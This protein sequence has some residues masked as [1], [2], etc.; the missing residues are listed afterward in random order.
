MKPSWGFVE[1][2][3]A[4]VPADDFWLGPAERAH[5]ARL[6]AAPR[7]ADWRLGRW[8]AKRALAHW[9][10]GLEA[11][12]AWHRLEVLPD[13]DGRPVATWRSRSL[14]EPLSLSHRGGRA[15]AVVGAAG[16]AV[17]CDLERIEPRSE[18]FVCD[19]FTGPERQAVGEADPGLR[20]LVANLIWSAK[21]SVSKLLGVGLS[22]DTRSIEIALDPAPRADGRWLPFRALR[23]ARGER[24]Y[25]CWRA[26]NG[27]IATAVR[28]P[29]IVTPVELGADPRPPA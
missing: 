1:T 9:L 24:F 19:Y 18:T 16:S 28:H 5:L 21:E 4:D 11:P 6:P 3:A 23:L 22:I 13:A 17:G 27:W 7:R 20:D 10:G 12:D 26:R 15:L 2:A 8:A 29:A 25:G 14:G